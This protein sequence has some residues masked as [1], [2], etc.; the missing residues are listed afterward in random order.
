LNQWQISIPINGLHDVLKEVNSELSVEGVKFHYCDSE[1]VGVVIMESNTRYEAVKEAR[2]LINK[3]LSRICFA[4]NTEATISESGEYV[5]DI[6]NDPN[7]ETM[8]S[9]LNMRWS[10]VKEDP[11]ITLSKIASIS[12]E[13]ETLDLALTYYKLGEYSNPLRIESF[14]SCMTVLT[15]SLLKKDYVDTKDLKMK[16]KDILQQRDSKFDE[17]MFE[18]HWKNSY[19]DERC[20]IAHG[21]GSKLI[22]PRM[23]AEYEKLVNIVGYWAREVIY[24]YIDKFK[25]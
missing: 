25:I 11:T 23:S 5:I 20:S 19:S 8:Y 7:T 12:A 24:H 4:Y 1:R 2:Y 18:D 3:S 22:D 14:F 10:Y 16:I 9:S 21:K 6:S 17:L 15:R 13:K